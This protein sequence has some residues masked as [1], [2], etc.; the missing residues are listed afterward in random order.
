MDGGPSGTVPFRLRDVALAAFL[1]TVVSG[2][3]HAAL[4]PV[5]ALLARDLGAGVGQAEQPVALVDHRHEL[6]VPGVVDRPDHLGAHPAP[7]S[8]D[9][10]VEHRGIAG[11]SRIGLLVRCGGH[12]VRFPGRPPE[13]AR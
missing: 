13:R 5:L 6:E 10:H 3:G 7:R 9:P 2:T 1:P 4:L 8:Q 12:A 11:T